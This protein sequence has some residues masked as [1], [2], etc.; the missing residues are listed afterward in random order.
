M[1]PRNSATNSFMKPSQWLLLTLAVAS[2]VLAVTA[3]T[4]GAR[5]RTGLALHADDRATA[6]VLGRVTGDPRRLRPVRPGADRWAV[7]L[8]VT[9]AVVRGEAPKDRAVYEWG[10]GVTWGRS[11]AYPEG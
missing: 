5:E 2:A 8:R 7:T 11:Q 10:L 4:L 1:I 6:E 9:R 3:V